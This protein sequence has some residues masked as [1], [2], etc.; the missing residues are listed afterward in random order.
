MPKWP[1]SSNASSG[2]RIEW[3][4]SRWLG[5][6]LIALGALAAT[7]LCLSALPVPVRPWA[8]LL[9]LLHGLRLARREMQRPVWTLEWAGGDSPAR[10]LGPWG[11][12]TWSGV[13]VLFRGPMATLT[14]RDA[15]G[16]RRR[17][18]WWPDTLPAAA[19]RQLRLAAAVSRRSDKAPPQLAA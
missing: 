1:A 17:E 14:G 19:R 8:A 7:A 4:P 5:L 9:A 10:R 18:V 12:Q 11:E 6:A 15:G 3:R 16:R 13:R 2:C